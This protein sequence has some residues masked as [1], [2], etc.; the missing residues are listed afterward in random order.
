MTGEGAQPSG[1]SRLADIVYT[2]TNEPLWSTDDSLNPATPFGPVTGVELERTEAGG[3][4]LVFGTMESTDAATV[5]ITDLARLA[6]VIN[7]LVGVDAAWILAEARAGDV[8]RGDLKPM[9]DRVH[10]AKDS[11]FDGRRTS[12]A[13]AVYNERADRLWARMQV[14]DDEALP[15]VTWRTCCGRESQCFA[16]QIRLTHETG[17][18]WSYVTAGRATYFGP[19]TLDELRVLLRDER[20]KP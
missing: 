15:A 14:A 1:D 4:Q 12:A 16:T 10:S 13:W 2:M 9:A 19:S 20:R 11:F 17:N 6:G 5:S 8:A 3:F 7:Q 18:L